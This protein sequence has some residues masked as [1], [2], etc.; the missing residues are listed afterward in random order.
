[1]IRYVYGNERDS[2]TY[3]MNN[4]INKD[5]IGKPRDDNITLSIEFEPISIIFKGQPLDT[6]TQIDFYIS[7]LLYKKNESLKELINTTSFLYERKPMYEN[8]TVSFYN[9]NNP[10]KFTLIFKDIPRSNNYI[11]DLQ[12]Q[13]NA[14]IKS[15]LF[16]EEF[17]IFTKEVDLTDIAKKKSIL[18]LIL[19]PILG[20]VFIL[21]V[22]VLVIIFLRLKRKNNNLEEDLK[23]FAYSNDIQKNVIVKEQKEMSKKE[24]DYESTFI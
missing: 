13:V 18:W 10:Q 21:I 7:G 3:I 11:Y 2:Y 19:G 16:N 23:S 6:D 17:L 20:V 24:M 8:K 9:L 22:V 5:Y 14:F 15:N 12:L 1:M 4:I